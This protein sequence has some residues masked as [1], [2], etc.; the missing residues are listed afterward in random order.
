MAASK[1]RQEMIEVI[2]DKL[3][4]LETL[5]IM[6]ILTVVNTMIEIQERNKA[7]HD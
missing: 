3:N 4:K 2:A 5:S 7:A 1:Y 6:K